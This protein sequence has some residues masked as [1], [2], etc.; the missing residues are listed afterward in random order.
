MKCVE[1]LAWQRRGRCSGFDWR[2][3]KRATVSVAE[4]YGAR[5]VL[6]TANPCLIPT[7]NIAPAVGWPDGTTP[8]AADDFSVNE[9]AGGFDHSRWL[10]VLPNGDVLVAESNAPAKPDAKF[11]LTGWVMGLVKARAGAGVHSADRISLV[12]DADNN[13]EAEIRI[14]FLDT[15][16]SPFGMALIGGTLYVANTDAI[17]AFPNVTG[18]T[19]IEATGTIVAPLPARPDQP[20]PEQG[21]DRQPGWG[22]VVCDGWNIYGASTDCGPAIFSQR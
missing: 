20:S 17:V 18:A 10:H 14:V 3:V 2:F 16:R 5:P 7:V 1:T 12:R 22:T 15:L 19:S 11:S 21:P 8:I 4:G 13:G 9:F 6:P